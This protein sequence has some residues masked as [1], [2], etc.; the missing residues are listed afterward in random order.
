MNSALFTFRS[1]RNTK[2]WVAL[3]KRRKV[4]LIQDPNCIF[5]LIYTKST[6]IRNPQFMVL[7]C[8]PVRDWRPTHTTYKKRELFLLHKIWNKTGMVVVLTKLRINTWLHFRIKVTNVKYICSVDSVNC[9]LCCESIR[10]L[11]DNQ[12][13]KNSFF[14]S[15][16]YEYY[17]EI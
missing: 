3:D 1:W 11:S 4:S 17:A 16:L 6:D 13:Y 12:C 15:I 10:T 7:L 8:K 5:L 9:R 14:L 2:N